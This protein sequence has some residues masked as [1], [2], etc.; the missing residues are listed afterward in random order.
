MLKH[1][2]IPGLELRHFARCLDLFYETL[3][4]AEGQSAA[5]KL[6]G[7]RTRIIGATVGAHAAFAFAISVYVTT[8]FG[9]ARAMLRQSAP[10]PLC[11]LERPGAALQAAFSPLT[12]GEVYA[13]VLIVPA[14]VAAFGFAITVIGAA[15]I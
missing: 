5:T 12:R 4:D 11:Q 13:Q 10:Q 15:A 7:T 6:I 14:A 1:L 8:F 9:N 3:W 2:A